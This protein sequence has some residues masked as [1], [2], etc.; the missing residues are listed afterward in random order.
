MCDYSIVLSREDRALVNTCIYTY[1]GTVF[2][3]SELSNRAAK[4]LRRTLTDHRSALSDLPKRTRL[5]GEPI[6]RTPRIF[7]LLYPVYVRYFQKSKYD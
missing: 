7:R 6:L 1:C 5:L 2:D 3:S 4:D